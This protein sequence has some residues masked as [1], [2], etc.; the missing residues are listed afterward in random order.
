GSELDDV[1]AAQLGRGYRLVELLKQPLNS[2]MAVEEQVV[3]IYC[4]TNGILDDLPAEQV[5]RFESDLLEDFRTRHVD[6]L[7]A[8]RSTGQLPEGDKLA[9]AI[10]D[11]KARFVNVVSGEIAADDAAKRDENPE[12][13]VGGQA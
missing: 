4:G 12:D 5:R 10:A 2:P 7:D 3:S 11:F 1:S 13:F 8:I 6:I 9:D